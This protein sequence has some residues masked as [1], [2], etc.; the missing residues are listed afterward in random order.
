MSFLI[1]DSLNAN[2]TPVASARTLNTNFQP[3]ITRPTLCVYSVRIAGA[4]TANQTTGN[5]QFLSDAA[6]PPTTVRCQ[7]RL[8]FKV[9]GALTTMTES[10][11]FTLVYLV[12]AGHFVQL[13]STTEAGVVTFTRIAEV[14]IVL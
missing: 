5:V 11:D 12:P 13:K 8:D 6:N 4:L 7:A 14:E 9:T 2:F 3:S 1:T 10:C